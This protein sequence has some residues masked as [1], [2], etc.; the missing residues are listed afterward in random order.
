MT[1]YWR[2][3]SLNSLCHVRCWHLVRTLWETVYFAY[4]SNT[5]MKAMNLAHSICSKC[6][7]VWFFLLHTIIRCYWIFNWK[8]VLEGT[9]LYFP[10]F[11]CCFI[12]FF[13]ASMVSR[14]THFHRN[15]PSKNQ[16]SFK[17]NPCKFGHIMD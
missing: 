7:W 5:S 13:I 2:K 17:I 6:D 9:A 14:R 16:N 8:A 4:P 12:I 15:M 10:V 11:Y 3:I 1:K